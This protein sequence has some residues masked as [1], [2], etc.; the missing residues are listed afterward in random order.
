[1]TSEDFPDGYTPR[2]PMYRKVILA[3][4]GAGLASFNALYC[5]QALLPVL[6][7]DLTVTPATA[8]LTVSATTGML[9]LSIIPASVVSEHV[10]RR[11]VI[12]VS[13]VCATV[14]GLL[15]PLSTS[16]EMLIALRAL[17]GVAVAGVPATAMAYLSEEIHPKHVPHVMGLYVAGTSVGG[18]SGRVIPSGVLEFASWR[19]ALAVTV[20]VAI[21]VALITSWSL[22][23]QRR[24]QPKSLTLRSEFHAIAQHVK[25]PR[26]SALFTLAFLF[27]GAFVSVYN[28]VG[29]RLTSHFHLSEGLAGAIF[30]LYLSGTWSSTRAGAMVEKYGRARVLVGATIG[31][32]AGMALLFSPE[33][34]SSVLG[35]VLFT[36]CFFAAHSV[37]SGWVG[38]AATRNRAEASSMYL[39]CYYMGSSLVGWLSGRIFHA[40]GW[41]GLVMWLLTSLT[42][43]MV[44]AAL[45]AATTPSSA[46]VPDTSPQPKP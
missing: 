22:P 23:D 43:T 2:S 7:E 35:I 15:L 16:V 41:N 20:A 21:I 25:D 31:M 26:L 19:W 37:A 11:R 44:I 12:M 4:V 29:Y 38:V 5:T 39:F 3:M 40:W 28:Y 42:V 10:G 9:A 6:S 32:I 33:L 13:A 46:S 36:G 30:V 1:M 18:L 24:F 17:Q 27:M 8:S 14:V 34:M 45:M